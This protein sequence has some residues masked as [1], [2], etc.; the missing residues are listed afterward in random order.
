[1]ADNKQPLP[2]RGQQR[3][4]QFAARANHL[5]VSEQWPGASEPEYNIRE[6][7]IYGA[8]RLIQTVT[9][10]MFV[11]LLRE[12]WIERLPRHPQQP[13]TAIHYRVTEAGTAAANEPPRE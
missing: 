3:I 11:R 10:K 4:I 6:R 12:G 13:V 1:M 2:T 7:G 8:G 5:L 9:P